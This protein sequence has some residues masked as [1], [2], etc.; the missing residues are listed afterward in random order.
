[1]FHSPHSHLVPLELESQQL[2]HG[3][4]LEQRDQAYKGVVAGLVLRR[5]KDQIEHAVRVEVKVTDQ[6]LGRGE[7]AKSLLV[8][9]YMSLSTI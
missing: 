6:G 8:G 1:M 9:P 7:G 2:H 3:L 4:L 5:L